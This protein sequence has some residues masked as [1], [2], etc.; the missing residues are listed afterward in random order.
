[1]TKLQNN[2][3]LNLTFKMLF[4]LPYFWDRLVRSW[5]SG[6]EGGRLTPFPPSCECSRSCRLNWECMYLFPCPCTGTPVSRDFAALERQKQDKAQRY[7]KEGYIIISGHLFMIHS[8][9]ISIIF[10]SIHRNKLSFPQLPL[11]QSSP[12]PSQHV[13]L[14]PLYQRR[15]C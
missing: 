8:I 15:W 1:M 12:Q 14:A 4:I 11:S 2:Q 6:G 7:F 10:L 3:T 5:Q 13:L 9:I